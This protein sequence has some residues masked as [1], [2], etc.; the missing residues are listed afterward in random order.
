LSLSIESSLRERFPDLKVLVGRVE[1][2]TVKESTAELEDFKKDIVQQARGDYSLESIKD[3][4]VFRA[5][6]DF[7]W[8]IKVDP[9][10]IRPAAE[11]LIR[12]VVAGNP[13]PHINSLVDAYNLASIKTEIALAAFDADKLHGNLLM[14]FASEGEEFLG[15]GMAK[16]VKLTGGEVV[17]SDNE[18]LVAMYP[19]RDADASKITEDTKNTQLLVCGV[20]R[21]GEDRLKSALKVTFDFITRFCGGTVKPA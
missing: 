21:I 17:V 12:R 3:N 16:P 13:L 14:R 15:I 4:P 11:A 10:K 1:N 7:F 20:P 8:R 18:K 19:Y 6:R 9:T 5:Y 2:V